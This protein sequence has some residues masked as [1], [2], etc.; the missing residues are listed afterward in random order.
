MRTALVVSLLLA[1]V[2]V[3]RADICC[4]PNNTSQCITC[5]KHCFMNSQCVGA[6]EPKNAKGKMQFERLR[7][8]LMRSKG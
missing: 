4:C 7:A 2:A 1:T 5:T 3:A 8:R 6:C